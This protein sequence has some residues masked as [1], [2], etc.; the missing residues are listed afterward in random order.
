MD[1]KEKSVY[2]K[3]AVL[4]MLSGGRNSFLSACRLIESGFYIHMI[5]YDN[6]CMSGIEHAKSVAD[7]IIS[8]FGEERARF[9]GVYRITSSL[10][11]LQKTFLYETLEKLNQAYPN[12]IPA[13]I[14][15]LACH[16]GMY[17]QSIA[18]CKANE[19]SKLAEGSRKSQGSFVALPDMVKRYRALAQ[20]HGITLLLPVY[21]LNDDWERKLELADFGFIPKSAGPQCWLDYPV[22]NKL[23]SDEI[24]SLLAYYD[25]EIAPQLSSLIDLA[26]KKLI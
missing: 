25:H 4:L 11:R 19:I 9:A 10:Y 2:D 13:Q 3:K 12:L 22:G 21:D 7:R 18:Y 24:K 26:V 16:T 5:T 17:I 1:F 23:S 14:P 15:C 6:G 20:Q 8:N